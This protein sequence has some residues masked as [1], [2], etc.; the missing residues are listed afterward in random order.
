MFVCVCVCVLCVCVYV[1]LCVCVCVC[2]CMCACMIVRV[3]VRHTTAKE[4]VKSQREVPLSTTLHH[5]Q[6]HRHPPTR[7]CSCSVD[8]GHADAH[9]SFIDA[10]L[11]QRYHNH[12]IHLGNCNTH[13]GESNHHSCLQNNVQTLIIELRQLE[14]TI[15]NIL[16][17]TMY[18]AHLNVCGITVISR[19]SA[20]VKFMA[21]KRGWAFTRRSHLYV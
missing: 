8:S 3:S 9:R 14:R 7:T 17:Q 15:S 16:H 20:R 11:D 13:S 12:P 10:L 18:G 5:L 2:V 21:K 19:L 1:C 4:I 6:V